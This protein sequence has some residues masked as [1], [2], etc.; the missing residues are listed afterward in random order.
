MYLTGR[1][2]MRRVMARWRAANSS[3]MGTSVVRPLAVAH[4]GE[5]NRAGEGAGRGGGT[6]DRQEAERSAVGSLREKLS[7]QLSAKHERSAVGPHLTLKEWD[8]I[9]RYAVVLAVMLPLTSGFSAAGDRKDAKDQ[10]QG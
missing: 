7:D 10:L 9:A 6:P 4:G 5:S 2:W 3:C 8:M 1:P